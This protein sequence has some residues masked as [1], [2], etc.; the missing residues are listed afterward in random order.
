MGGERMEGVKHINKIR[1]YCDYVEEHLLNVERSWFIL[2]STCKDMP[3]I[4]DDYCYWYIDAMVKNHDVSKM[5]TEEFIPYQR[6][7]YPV[8][9][10]DNAI[11]GI[12]WQHHLIHN[13][14]HWENWTNIKEKFPNEQACHCVCMVID[15]MAMGMKFGDTAEEYYNANKHK[16]NIPGWSVEFINEI[17]KKLRDW[18]ENK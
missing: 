17:F 7:F 6:N 12:A 13:P 9:E 18:K 16:I 4:Y 15:W 2:Q 3:I 5:S 11:F 10:K 8:D 14:H 1:E